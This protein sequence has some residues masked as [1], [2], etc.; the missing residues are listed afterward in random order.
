MKHQ[1]GRKSLVSLKIAYQ[2]KTVFELFETLSSKLYQIM[3][4]VNIISNCFNNLMNIQ[5]YKCM[6][7][8]Q[9]DVRHVVNYLHQKKMEQF[10]ISV[11]KNLITLN[12]HLLKRKSIN[13]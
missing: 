3:I 13:L 12:K 10:V 1:T 9:L 6:I 5:K 7:I 4:Q 2:A 11:L 8:T